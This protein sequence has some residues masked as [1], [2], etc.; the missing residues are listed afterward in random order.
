M[1]VCVCMCVICV[2]TEMYAMLCVECS[3]PFLG[4]GGV[5]PLCTG[6]SRHILCPAD[7]ATQCYVFDDCDVRDI[8]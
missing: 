2:I 5:L 6:Y 8:M 1:C 3:G 7:R 4:G